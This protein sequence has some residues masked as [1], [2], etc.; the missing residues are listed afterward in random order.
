MAV[1]YKDGKI[2]E[3]DDEDVDYELVEPTRQ[4]GSHINA[5]PIQS[6]VQGPRLFY[7]ARFYNQAMPLKVREAPLIQN[8]DETDPDGRSFDQILGRYAGAQFLDEDAEVTDV[9]P[10]YIHYKNAAGEKKKKAIYNSQVFNRKSGITNFPLVQKGD[11]VTAGQ[12]VA[13][14]NYTDDNGNLALGLNARVGLVPYKGFSMD[15]AIVI[16]QAF[17]DKFLSEHM[18]THVKEFDRDIK[19]G[20]DH[21]RSLFPQKYTKEQLEFLDDKGVVKP[22]TILKEGDPIILATRPRVISSSGANVGK[23]TKSMSQARNDAS[24][25]WESSYPAEVVDVYESKKG[26]KVITRAYAPTKDGDKIVFRSGQ[27]S[28]VS[29]VIP[30]EQMPRTKDGE[31]LDVLLNPLSVPSRTNNSLL[32][33]MMLGKVAKK[34][35]KPIV[36]PGFT[37]PGE[38]WNDIVKKYL[39]EAGVSDK[40]EIYDPVED[41]ILE[42]P[43]LVGNAYMMRL[44]HT[45]ESKEDARGQGGY[46]AWQSPSK[47]SGPGGSSKRLSGLESTVMLSSGAYNNLREGSTLR[48]QA[49]DEYWRALRMGLTPPKPGT[50]FAW[51]KT[52]NMMIGA[53][54][55]PRKVGKGVLRLAP[56]RD[57]DLEE[58]RPLEITKGELLN[59]NTLAP[60][61]GGLFDSALV[62]NNGWGK[63]TL[64]HRYP[65]PAYEEAVRTILGLKKKELQD[66]LAGKMD[67][68]E[69]LQKTTPFGV[70]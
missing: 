52:M 44:H 58:K 37:K 26:A 20:K 2:E 53:G 30:D 39:D 66:I 64:P 19:P 32:F 68:P 31:P 35:G 16:S 54:I 14:S 6:A 40:E 47:G 56:A 42:Q 33:E 5:I 55:N 17:A 21:F 27:K 59:L 10:D 57:E 9:T 15:D 50:P 38:K 3:V 24:M 46:D 49:N 69:H 7:G 34:T 45:A 51:E 8:L 29:K 36:L 43:V 11:K 12:L 23:L 4:F 13:S 48:G 25:V 62:G 60:V 41:K 67:L 22:G 18:E 70:I 1:A 63:I 61:E 65:N 28:V